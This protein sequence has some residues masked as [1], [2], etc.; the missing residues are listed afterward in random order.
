MILTKPNKS[1]YSEAEAAAE[2]GVSV[3][4]LRSLIKSRIVDREEDLNNV[5]AAIYQ[6][7]DLVMLRF[8]A[9]QRRFAPVV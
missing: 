1:Q 3:D 9:Q 4:E 7:P 2:I 8:L 6:P 5:P